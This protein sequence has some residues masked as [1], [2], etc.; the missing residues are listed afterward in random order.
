MLAGKL[1]VTMGMME[2]LKAKVGR[3]AFFKPFVKSKEFDDDFWSDTL[4]I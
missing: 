1:V 4:W 2:F 3:I